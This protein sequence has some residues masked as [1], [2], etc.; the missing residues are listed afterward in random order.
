MTTRFF[1]M[2]AVFNFHLA[3]SRK[4]GHF[5]SCE[6]MIGHFADKYDLET[7][8]IPVDGGKMNRKRSIVSVWSEFYRFL[9]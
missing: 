8:S 1:S 7:D 6:T 9:W 4:P 2:L 5:S 3:C